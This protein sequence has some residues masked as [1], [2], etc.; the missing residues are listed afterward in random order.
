MIPLIMYLISTCRE[1]GLSATNWSILVWVSC[2]VGI[3][4]NEQ[5]DQLVKR[6]HPLPI[7]FLNPLMVYLTEPIERLP[8]WFP[9]C[10]RTF[11]VYAKRV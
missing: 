4:S 2:H 6:G 11:A 7:L 5:V 10:G 1:V 8:S 9:N 3:V